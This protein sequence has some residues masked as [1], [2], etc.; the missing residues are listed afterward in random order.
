MLN[1]YCPS[2]TAVS[3]VCKSNDSAIE[4]RFSS[5]AGCAQIKLNYFW[6]FLSDNKIIF[7]ILLWIV[8]LFELLF[9]YLAIRM[10]IFI[11]GIL[12]GALFG[13]IYMAENYVNFIYES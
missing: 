5:E 12:S 1:I 4:C 11:F 3:N 13:I 6:Q 9:G 8:A 10:T 7:A 2:V